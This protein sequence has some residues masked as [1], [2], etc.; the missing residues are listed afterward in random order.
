MKKGQLQHVFI[1]L[2]AILVMGVLVILGYR[3]ISVL[4]DQQC[5]ISDSS[6]ERTLEDHLESSTRYGAVT[7]VG[8]DAPCDYD[9][10]CLA[11]SRFFDNA[12][13]NHVRE[14][15][16]HT[17]FKNGIIKAN[18]QDNIQRN[19]YLIH[20]RGDEI[21]ETK[22]ILWSENLIVIDDDSSTTP[23]VEYGVHCVDISSGQFTFWVKGLGRNGVEVVTE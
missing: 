19:I 14:E 11:D 17:Y 7:Q 3:F 4:M 1:Y 2:M 13:P 12:V 5:D 20:K 16:T 6:F 8:I 18:A 15:D 22:D 23:E 10:I 21:G 9:M